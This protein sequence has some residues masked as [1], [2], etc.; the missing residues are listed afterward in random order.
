MLADYLVAFD[1]KGDAIQ[2]W[3]IDALPDVTLG[4][5][6]KIVALNLQVNE[7]PPGADLRWAVA[8]INFSWG[9][10]KLLPKK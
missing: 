1:A 6:L 7:A 4:R 10:T 9:R 2:A 3:L 5:S 8:P